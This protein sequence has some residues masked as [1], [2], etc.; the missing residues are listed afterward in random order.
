[1]AKKSGDGI[2]R[3]D[4]LR[5]VVAGAA[6]AGGM[7]SAMGQGPG[8]GQPP[9]AGG[10]GGTTAPL[11]AGVRAVW[12]I[13]K[14]HHEA[15]PTRARV[16]INGLWRWQPAAPGAEQVPADAWGYFKVPGDWPGISDYMHK[17]SQ[18]LYPHPSWKDTRLDEVARAWHQR[19]ITIPKEWMGRRIVL[20]AECVN[21][22]A[23]VFVGGKRAGEILFPAGEV[24]L[25]S[26]CQ[27]GRKYALS[28]LVVAMPL[29]G[30]ML[31]YS[32][33][34]AAKEV[35]GSVE[36]RGLCGDVYLVSTPRAARV[37]DVRV[38][39][40]V[41]KRQITVG[42]ALAGLDPKTRYTLRAKVMDGDRVV[43]TMQ[44]APFRAAELRD[45][46][47]SFADA[48]MA[49]K[50]WDL[51]TPQN[52]YRLSLTLFAAD[53]ALD[54]ALPVRFGYREFWIEGRDFYLNGTRLFISS[55]PMDNAGVS[56]HMS[57]YG[58]ARESLTRLK[59]IGINFVYGHNYGC[60]PG[61]HLQ[62]E[63]IL[64]AADDVGMLVAL[65][66]PHF[67]QYDWEAADADQHN[68]YARHAAFYVHVAGSHPSVV[69]YSTSHNATG[70]N[71]DMNPDMIDGRQR[72]HNPWSD[73]GAARALRAQA[74]IESLDPVRIV[75]HHSSGNLGTMHTS[76]FYPNMVPA[77][78]LSDWLEHWATVG[79]KPF[80]TVEYAAPMSWDWTMYRGWY[81]GRRTF[82][83]AVVPWEFCQAEWSAQFLGDRSYRITEPEK[84]N[85][86]WEAGQFRAGKL[87]YRWDYPYPVGANVFD[88]QH[89]I[90]GR[91]TTDN[92]RAFRT[93]GMSANSP[94][95]HEFFWRL[96][97]G[98][99]RRRRE[100][101]VNWEQIQRPG[102]SADY[103][104]D[105]YERVDMAYELSDWEPTADG[106]ALLRN[107]QPLL[108]YLA[109]KP[110][111]FTSKDHNFLV[112]ETVEKQI[113][114]INNSRVPVTCEWEWSVNLPQAAGG[115][116][117]VAV[118]TG[119]QERVP[120]QFALPGTL[121]PGSYEIALTARF[122]DGETQKDSFAIHVMGPL[123]S[124]KQQR[125][126]LFDPKGETAA[127]LRA[128]QVEFAL[129]EAGA[130]LSGYDTLIIGKA[131]LAADGVAPDLSRVRNGLRAI[132]FEQTAEALEKRLGFRTAEYGLRQV[133]ARVPD[134]PV[135]KGLGADH[136]RDWRGEATLTPARLRYT[137]ND[138]V[139]NGAPVVEWCGIPVTRVWRCGNRGNVASVLIEKPARG[140]F[141]P[142]VDGGFA[143]QY[144]PLLEYREG[145]GVVLFCQ[146]DVTG[147][148]ESEP[149]AQ[150]I[151]WNLLRYVAGWKPAPRRTALYA[152][153]A[154][155]RK[156]LEAAGIALESYRGGQLTADQTLIVGPGGGQQLS[157]SRGPIASWVKAGGNLLAVGLD[158]AEANSFLPFRV[159]MQK[160]E[161]ICTAF[162]PFGTGSPYAGVCPADTMNRDPRDLWLVSAGATVVGNGALAAGGDSHVALC[163][164][165]P[166]EFDWR[167]P[168]VS[169]DAP[170]LMN[171][172][173]TFRRTS[174]LLTRLLGNLGVA[175]ATPLL[176]R[177]GR[178]PAPGGEEKRWLEGLYL[179]QP[180]EW[181]DP[182]RFFRW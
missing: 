91:Y 98:V 66:Q 12:D 114:V 136:L 160:A 96:K 159:T 65:S 23:A 45:G 22:Y 99:D 158:E 53:K 169:P 55:V 21:S 29:K 40:S 112:G 110:A 126:A 177:F 24:D 38:D 5:Q 117:R 13:S 155:G 133:F 58:P 75:Y 182:Y 124:A 26:V 147:R 30:V 171:L 179:D 137:T 16:C 164:L 70:Y 156:H 14:A 48:W 100:L 146:L 64:R 68:G 59:G 144:S 47:I 157:S 104:G 41:R 122:S 73:R 153:E 101:A 167:K 25:T 181:D 57:S 145:E 74:I 20:S 43:H 123:P 138:D 135:L 42:A 151:A 17:E 115:R 103:I 163:Q 129:V 36:R 71:E 95:D 86:R 142:I 1:M 51:H 72:P 131:A 50:L 152:G 4:F 93:W 172:K 85:L 31:S 111:R 2:S 7:G 140:D 78:E 61:S 128:M 108:A 39:T 148:T 165:A 19:E 15:T 113:V 8:G 134:H 94:W 80:F 54:T 18:T 130:D 44:S 107:N 88:D 52:T 149:A 76:N 92:W 63:E 34:N 49:E 119:N 132:V 106:Q 62:F 67:G 6:I 118:A 102:F 175:A 81:R 82:G 77:Q 178:P 180:E 143:L 69:A 89:E 3:R 166:W 127:M 11:P 162:E 33:S 116:G 37:E 173:R 9:G 154:A 121:P 170:T 139:F 35:A 176:D 174:V 32:D 46:R 87:W 168:P 79:V 84:V 90:R 60:E 28:L 141:M 150:G 10:S 83:S 125:L 27:P 56:A 109:G 161:H 97:P 105:Q 120:I